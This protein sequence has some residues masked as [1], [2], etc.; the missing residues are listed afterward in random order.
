MD[1][2]ESTKAGSCSDIPFR[3]YTGDSMAIRVTLG[4]IIRQENGFQKKEIMVGT[5]APGAIIS[6]AELCGRLGIALSNSEGALLV[7]VNNKTVLPESYQLA[8]IQIGDHVELMMP[9]SGG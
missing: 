2:D 1:I 5:D 6:I 8:I 3:P 4:E 7:F 9:L